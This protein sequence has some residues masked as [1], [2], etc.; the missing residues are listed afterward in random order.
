MGLHQRAE[1][2]LTAT[3]AM[4]KGTLEFSIEVDPENDCCRPRQQP[5]TEK[6]RYF[7]FIRLVNTDD[8]LQMAPVIREMAEWEKKGILKW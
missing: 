5:I 6:S 3:T 2:D 8:S 4:L 7:A 1:S